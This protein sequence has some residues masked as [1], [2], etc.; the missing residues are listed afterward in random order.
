MA[1]QYRV[2]QSIVRGFSNHRRIEIL[3]RL[4]ASPGLDLT[5]IAR[6]CGV[7]L[8]TASEHVRRLALAGLVSKRAQNRRV[9]HTVTPRGRRVLTFLRT[10]E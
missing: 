10:L 2:F 4:E 9:L 7:N 6:D 1:R 8:K 5:A 3:Y